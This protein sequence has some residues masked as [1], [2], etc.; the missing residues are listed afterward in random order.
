MSILTKIIDKIRKQNSDYVL[1]LFKAGLSLN[2]IDQS[3]S[4]FPPRPIIKKN[5][6]A[7]EL[8]SPLR[9][10]RLVVNNSNNKSIDAILEIK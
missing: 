4:W 3:S 8:V 7:L 1:F 9:H 2:T 10:L 5:D 6:N